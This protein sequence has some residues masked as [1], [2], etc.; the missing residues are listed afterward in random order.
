[1]FMGQF[2]HNLD[3]KNR[4]IL[5]SS[6]REQLG[7]RCV[8]TCGFEGCLTVYSESEWE[9][10]VSRLALLPETLKESRRITRMFLSGA[11]ACEFDKQGRVLLPQP[12]KDFAKIEKEVIII[13]KLS[14]IE[15][16]SNTAWEEYNTGDGAMT[17]E[18]A[19]S[20][21]PLGTEK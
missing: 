16:W 9:T 8:I 7:N 17:L 20:K 13:G 12:L 19:A 10:F 18:D 4:L 21:L 1:M 15:I 3:A 2:N 11:T 6:F 5:P 14:K